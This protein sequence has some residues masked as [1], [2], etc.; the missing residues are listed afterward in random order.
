MLRDEAEL[1]EASL[2]ILQKF[3]S[4]YAISIVLSNYKLFVA[5]KNDN[6]NYRH[7]STTTKKS[8]ISNSLVNTKTSEHLS[9]F[10]FFLTKDY[11]HQPFKIHH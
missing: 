3:A 1:D 6:Q 4:H 7:N 9:Q 10:T 2:V 5:T 11:C 8:V